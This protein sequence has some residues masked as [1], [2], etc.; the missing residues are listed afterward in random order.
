MCSHEVAALGAESKT[1]ALSVYLVADRPHCCAS[2]FT[3]VLDSAI[4]RGKQSYL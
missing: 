4:F 2:N 3:F 1:A